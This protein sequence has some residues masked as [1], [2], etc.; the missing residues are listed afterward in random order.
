MPVKSVWIVNEK[1][2]GEGGGKEEGGGE[3]EEE[4]GGGGGRR[5]RK[6]QGICVGYVRGEEG[7][8]VILG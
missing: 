5:R 2:E 3:R 7:G 1:G 6:R 8:G 4:G